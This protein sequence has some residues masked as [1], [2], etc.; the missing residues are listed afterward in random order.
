[1]YDT[2]SFFCDRSSYDL[3]ERVV[4]RHEEMEILVCTPLTALQW[5]T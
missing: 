5:T 4:P 3:I 1:M 2:N